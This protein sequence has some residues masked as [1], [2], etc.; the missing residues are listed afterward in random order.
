[1]RIFNGI[2]AVIMIVFAILQWNDP[3]ALIW[4]AVYG[5]VALMAGQGC[6][7]VSIRPAILAGI[8]GLILGIMFYIPDVIRWIGNG[9]PSISGQMK[10][11]SPFIE[12]VR[13]FFGLLIALL[14]M[15]YLYFYD[16]SVRRK[17][18]G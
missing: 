7:G 15:G 17:V 6:F 10:A 18:E 1:M 2:L 9:M 13:E 3:D 8:A 5:Y 4:I 12:L 16:R 11:E 14:V